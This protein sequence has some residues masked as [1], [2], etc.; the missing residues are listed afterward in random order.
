MPES[1]LTL[2]LTLLPGQFAVCRL[3]AGA[4]VPEWATTGAFT[5]ITRTA[6]ELSVVCPAENV[7]PDV[8]AEGPWRCLKVE[9]PLDFALTGI[10]ASIAVPLAEASVS[11]FAVST[12]DTD[13]V[14]VTAAQVERAA[15][16]LRQAGHRVRIDAGG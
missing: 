1:S 11:I 8:R 13:Y 9:G 14:L 12:Y 7:P 4:P 2:T 15:E 5:S 16:V 3:D 10:L 6:D